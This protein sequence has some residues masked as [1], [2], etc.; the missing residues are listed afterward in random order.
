MEGFHVSFYPDKCIIE[1][2]E[3]LNSKLIGKIINNIYM[4]DIDSSLPITCSVFWKSSLSEKGVAWARVGHLGFSLERELSRL[5]ESW[6]AWARS[7]TLK[8]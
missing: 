8:P 5:R 4:I 7:G 3:S 6:L 2:K 1:S